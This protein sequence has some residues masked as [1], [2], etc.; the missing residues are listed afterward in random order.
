MPTNAHFNTFDFVHRYRRKNT[1]CLN[2]KRDIL[3][4][5]CNLITDEVNESEKVEEKWNP[6]V[7]AHIH[8]H[9]RLLSADFQA[10]GLLGFL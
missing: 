6:P 9:N 10:R 8:G 1:I 7:Q 3:G 5:I 4:K 2:T